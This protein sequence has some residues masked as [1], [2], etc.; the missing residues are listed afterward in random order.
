MNLRSGDRTLREVFRN[1][2]AQAGMWASFVI[3]RHPGTQRHPQMSL[4]QR[5]HEI[6]TL[7]PHRSN[8]PF[9]I[10]NRLWCPHWSA[11]NLQFKITSQSLVQLPREDRIA[12]VDQEPITVVARE[13]F[14]ELLHSPL[15]RRSRNSLFPV[16]RSRLEEE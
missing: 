10:C 8:Q 15:Q 11:Q 2:R 12:V 1:L 5:D 6:Q 14:S 13:G 4:V 7:P 16:C 3:V 9:T